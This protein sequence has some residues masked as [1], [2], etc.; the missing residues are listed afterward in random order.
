[1]IDSVLKWLLKIIIPF[2]YKN[3]NYGLYDIILII[4]FPKLFNNFH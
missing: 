1:M 4:K 2:I 3:E